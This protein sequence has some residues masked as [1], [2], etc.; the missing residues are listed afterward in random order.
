MN[1]HV[2]FLENQQDF[3]RVMDE[4]KDHPWIGF[5]TEFVGEKY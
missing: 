1:E 3:D 5:D 2:H 4:I